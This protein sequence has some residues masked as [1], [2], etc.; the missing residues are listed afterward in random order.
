MRREAVAS[1]VRSASRGDSVEPIVSDSTAGPRLI[2][3]TVAAAMAAAIFYGMVAGGFSD[4]LSSLLDA[5]WGRVTIIDLYLG[6]VL[7]GAWIWYREGSTM[8]S[9]PWWIALAIGGNLTAG[10]YVIWASRRAGS[11]TELLTGKA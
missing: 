6:F 10:I 1:D 3:W 5:P 7:F 4:G 9:T 8:R 2:G 11:M